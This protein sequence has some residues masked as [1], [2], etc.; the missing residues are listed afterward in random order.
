MDLI[1]AGKD[2]ED[3]FASSADHFIPVQNVSVQTVA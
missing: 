2:D 3:G 1:M